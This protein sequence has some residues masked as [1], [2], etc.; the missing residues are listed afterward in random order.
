[1]IKVY[2]TPHYN[3]VVLQCKSIKKVSNF[4]I[5]ESKAEYS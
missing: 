3:I 4:L 1:M 5:Y 2:A